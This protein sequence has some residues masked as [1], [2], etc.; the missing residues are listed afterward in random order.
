MLE[1]DLFLLLLPHILSLCLSFLSNL[2]FI[3]IVS[4]ILF[5]IFTFLSPDS[6]VVIAIG[7]GQDSR[8]VGIRVPVG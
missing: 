6:I 8:R 4:S 1:I 3:F 7:Y 5:F 2:D